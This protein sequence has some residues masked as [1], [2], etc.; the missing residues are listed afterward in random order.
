MNIRKYLQA[1]RGAGIREAAC[2]KSAM[3]IKYSTDYKIEDNSRGFKMQRAK[4]DTEVN[5]AVSS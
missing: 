4:F 5:T 1:N 3:D 2:E